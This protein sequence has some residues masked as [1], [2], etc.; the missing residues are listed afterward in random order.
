MFW[1]GGIN[2][3]K[4]GGV[5]SETGSGIYVYPY[6]ARR[7]EKAEL[8]GWETKV[9]EFLSIEIETRTGT[10]DRGK[11]RASQ[12]GQRNIFGIGSRN[13]IGKSQTSHQQR[14]ERRCD[15]GG[16]GGVQGE[17]VQDNKKSAQKP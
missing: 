1:G 15:V 8:E 14:R 6:L 3:E 11:G 17:K 2:W 10:M 5:S 9:T 16:G 13:S 7:G 12:R 4:M